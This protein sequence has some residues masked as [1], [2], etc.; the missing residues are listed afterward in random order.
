[1]KCD[2]CGNEF[3]FMKGGKQVLVKKINNAII[4][5]DPRNVMQCPDCQKDKINIDSTGAKIQNFFIECEDRPYR[6]ILE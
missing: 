6:K 1:M 2:F 5:S 3:E 4:R